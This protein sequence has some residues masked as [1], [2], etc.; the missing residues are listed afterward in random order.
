[1]LRTVLVVGV[2]VAG[3][4]GC[5]SPRPHGP[6]SPSTPSRAKVTPPPPP[7]EAIRPRY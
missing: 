6:P 4:T 2:L 7:I 1:M 5:A 3:L